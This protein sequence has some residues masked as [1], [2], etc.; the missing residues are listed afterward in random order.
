MSDS[1]SDLEALDLLRSKF[2]TVTTLLALT[3]PQPVL[4]RR[5]FP[6]LKDS[7]RKR[8]RILQAFRAVIVREVEVVTT[9]AYTSFKPPTQLNTFVL[10]KD[11]ESYNLVVMQELQE[12]Y[13]FGS[14]LGVP[15]DSRKTTV[16]V[17]GNPC[18]DQSLRAA[19]H[20]VVFNDGRS[21]W[22]DVLNDPW[23]FLEKR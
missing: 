4:E 22:S 3:Q 23:E 8:L 13:K 15:L 14:D 20:D 9:A 21:Y 11:I 18:E 16:T 10:N 1:V 17:I 2:R 12:E 5:S 6:I 19:N 7:Q